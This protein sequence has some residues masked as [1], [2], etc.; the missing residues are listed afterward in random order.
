MWSEGSIS[1][2]PTIPW[3]KRPSSEKHSKWRPVI[4]DLIVSLWNYSPNRKTKMTTEN[5]AFED[6]SPITPPE[7]NIP[8]ENGPSQKEITSSN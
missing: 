8:P 5:Q 4:G 3:K 1:P 6:V 7:T 2:F